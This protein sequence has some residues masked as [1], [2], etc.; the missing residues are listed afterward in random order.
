MTYPKDMLREVYRLKVNET[1]IV[2]VRATVPEGFPKPA[3]DE[4]WMKWII[5]HGLRRWQMAA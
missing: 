1:P 4:V 2:V 5:T 3:L